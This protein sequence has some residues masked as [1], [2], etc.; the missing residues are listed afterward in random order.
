MQP[1]SIA[2]PNDSL[3]L[4]DPLKIDYQDAYAIRIPAKFAVPPAHLVKLFFECIP[5]WASALLGIR[6][7]LAKLIGLKTAQG[8]NVQQQLQEYRGEPG[9]SI[10]L[11]H[12]LK[13]SDTEILTGENDSHLDFRLSYIGQTKQDTFEIILATTVQMNSWIGRLYFLP[14]KPIH[15]ILVKAL[16]KRMAK[17]LIKKEEGSNLPVQ[18]VKI[19]SAGSGESAPNII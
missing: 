5:N 10:A 19:P 18:N 9:Q 2:I 15:R 12:T 8:I 4:Q 6:E 13:R 7:V 17:R 11:F 1:Y 14:V 3:I 16:L